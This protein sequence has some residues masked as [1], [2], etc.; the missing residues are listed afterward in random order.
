MQ[1]SA[2]IRLTKTDL[3]RA[4]EAG[5]LDARQ[6]ERLWAH[7]QEH[8][9]SDPRPRFDLVHLLWYA[10]ALIVMAAMGLFS[11]EAW[12]RFGGFALT[13]IAV[14]YAV[15]FT[16]AGTYLW[17]RRGLR[18]PGGLLITVAVTMAPLAVYGV[19][20]AFGWWSHGDPGTY[21]DFFRW[22]KSSWLFMDLAAIIAAAVALRFYRFPFIVMPLAI[23]LWFMSMD[24]APWLIGESWADWEKRKALSVG[25]GIA[26]LAVA[27][28][29]DLRARGD[30]AFW[31]H[32]FGLMTFW[33]GLTALD[34]DNEL[35]KA[36]YC[37]LNV[38]LVLFS[39]FMQRRAYAVFG[40]LGVATYLGHLSYRVF[41]DSLLFPLALSLIGVAVIA[42]GL[43]YF[44]RRQAVETWLTQNL[45]PGLHALRPAHA[46]DR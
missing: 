46:G 39:I 16:L 15:C 29:V 6:A 22:I 3:V 24:L 2:S 7:F 36:L 30:F 9:E 11:T 38:V 25:F 4:V 43:I 1:T 28:F 26:V 20:D 41:K 18:T 17:Q 34:S 14:L 12:S 21:R 8:D 27:W 42:I 32:L 40:A 33:G 35:G 45:P 37:A 5:V 44:R 13:S 10:G 23:A 31:L 19:Q